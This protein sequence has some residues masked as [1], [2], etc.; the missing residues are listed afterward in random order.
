MVTITTWWLKFH[1][2]A[3]PRWRLPPRKSS[4][5]SSRTQRKESWG[6]HWIVQFRN[7]INL[8]Y[9]LKHICNCD[10]YLSNVSRYVK[11]F[12]P[13]HG[14]I[15]NYGAIPQT[16]EVGQGRGWTKTIVKHD[17]SRIPTTP[18]TLPTARATTILSMCARLVRGSTLEVPW[19]R[20][21][22]WESSPWS[23][24]FGILKKVW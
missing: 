3:T 6:S 10:M 23:T 20:L 1:G 12:F 19:S 15:W 5:Q 9:L 7:H 2:G 13:H 8:R 4:T 17:I 18:T 11:N 22:S 16:W 21:R 24:R 14:Y